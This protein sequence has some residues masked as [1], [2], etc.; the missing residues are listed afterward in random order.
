[1]SQN[2]TPTLYIGTIT[3]NPIFSSWSFGGDFGGSADPTITTDAG[4]AVI[5]LTISGATFN[6]DPISWPVTGSQPPGGFYVQT[7]NDS[8]LNIYNFNTLPGTFAFTLITS[9][10][11]IDPT[12][13]DTQPIHSTEPEEKRHAFAA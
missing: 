2:F 5:V 12:I 13:V 4:L 6:D 3:W 1:M 11:P 7:I 10:G 8:Q 9:R